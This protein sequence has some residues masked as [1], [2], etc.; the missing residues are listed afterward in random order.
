MFISMCP[1][2]SQEEFAEE[3]SIKVTIFQILC[4][5]SG[6]PCSYLLGWSHHFESFTVATMTWLTVMEY[7][8]DTSRSF[9]H[10]WLVLGFVTILTRRVP[11]VKQEL[12]ILPQHLSSLSCFDLR[13]LITAFDIFKLFLRPFATQL[14]SPVKNNYDHLPSLNFYATIIFVII[15]KGVFSIMVEHIILKASHY[16]FGIINVFWIV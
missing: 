10:S 3:I 14:R 12:I 16:P 13:I 4:F 6:F 1:V 2:K 5:Q 15:S 9:P 11:L 7:L 8:C